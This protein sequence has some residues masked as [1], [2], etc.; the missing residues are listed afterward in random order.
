MKICLTCSPGGHLLQ[1]LQ[2]E[3]VYS[4]Y[5]HFFLTFKELTTEDLEKKEKVYFIKNPKRSILDTFISFFQSLLIF[6]KEK[7]DIIISTGAGVTIPVCYLAKL[8]M[9]KIIYIESFSRV[10]FPS[11][12]G[13][14]GYFVS[15]LFI[16]QW[17]P[18]L[19]FYK[20][21]KYGGTI[22]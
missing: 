21:A 5:D 15:D 11:L 20:N 9:K 7:P 14:L 3:K 10:K 2:L 19:K 4:K 18:L 6:L 17:K 8:F 13:K 1:I 22:F 16:V 12:A